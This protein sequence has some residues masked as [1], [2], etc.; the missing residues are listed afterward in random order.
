MEYGYE[1]RDVKKYAQFIN[2]NKSILDLLADDLEG[3][4]FLG[5]AE[6]YK[7]CYREIV[8]KELKKQNKNITVRHLR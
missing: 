8:I 2:N 4:C 6:D 7:C 1:Q 3:V 5:T